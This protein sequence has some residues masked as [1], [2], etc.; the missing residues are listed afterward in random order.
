MRR[1]LVLI[2]CVF[3]FV[4]ILASA[5]GI[6]LSSM[7]PEELQSLI[8]DAQKQLALSEPEMMERAID[9]LKSTWLN[10]DK[11]GYKSM[12]STSQHGYLEILHSQILY[13]SDKAAADESGFFYNM[14]CVIDFVLLSDYYGSAPYYA[15]AGI[16]SSVVVFNDGNMEVRTRS[17]FAQYSARTYSYDYSGIISSVRKLGSDYNA[18]FY[19]LDEE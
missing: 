3:F 19:L 8:A 4:P 17:V 10:D 14:Y 2:L 15:D 13:I 6:D 7:S 11:Y 9:L 1:F 16:N 18:V 5:E 12:M